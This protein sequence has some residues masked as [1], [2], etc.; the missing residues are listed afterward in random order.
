MWLKYIKTI[1]LTLNVVQLTDKYKGE[2]ID[3]QGPNILILADNILILKMLIFFGR[4]SEKSK[5]RK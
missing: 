1:Q 4:K 3:V 5:N 2:Y